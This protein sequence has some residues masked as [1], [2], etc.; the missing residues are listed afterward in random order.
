MDKIVVKHSCIIINDYTWGDSILLQN[1]FSIIDIFHNVTYIGIEYNENTKQLILPRGIDIPFLENIFNV[2][3]VIDY[4]CD[5][6]DRIEQ[7][8]LKFSPRDNVQKEALSF[9]VGYGNYQY[10]LSKSQLSLNLN[11]GKG[12]TYCS[13]V[14]ALYLSL[15]TIIIT[16]SIEWLNQWKNCIID[17]TDIDEKEIFMLVGRT[18]IYRLLRSDI[19]KYKFIL[20]S[21]DTIR[22]YANKKGW[23]AV[24]EL[25]KYM[26][27]GIKIFDESHLNFDNISKIDFHT[28]TYKTYYVTATPARSD[29]K[30]NSIYKLYFKNIPAIELFDSEEDPHTHYISFKYN[31]RPNPIQITKCKNRLGLDRNAY[32]EYITSN[33]NFYKM[34][35]YIINLALTH[36]GK[37]VIYIATNNGILKVKEWLE[38]NYPMLWGD[39]GIFTSIIPKEL[40]NSQLNKKIILS[41]T[42]S[43]G[44]A[45]DIKD[46]KMVVVAAEPF[47]SEVLARQTLGRTRNN[48]TFYIELVDMAFV[49]IVKFYRSKQHVF[50]KYALS[51]REINFSTPVD[52]NKMYD[53]AVINKSNIPLRNEILLDE[54]IIT[55]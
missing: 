6:Y 52:F 23:D 15:R 41:T 33:D 8:K 28:N 44:A 45:V 36:E 55:D 51:C 46:L 11:T 30:E 22:S 3:A 4:N 53:S 24:T 9:M 34:M 14:S 29:Q 38:Y 13:I 1:S 7:S 5:E 42:K 17:Y 39:I 19:S 27:V 20:A 50:L 26:K 37:C 16:T 12:K 43:L 54:I 31:S 25:F 40:K 32:C 18:S 48:N 10:T 35:T 2:S 21:H 47:K 49:Q